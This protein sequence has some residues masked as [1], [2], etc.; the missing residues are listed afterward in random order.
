M[1]SIKHTQ[2]SSVSFVFAWP[3]SVGPRGRR[4][5]SRV[6]VI[7]R[8]GPRCLWVS[9]RLAHLVAPSGQRVHWGSR[10]QSGA[11]HGCSASTL[12]CTHA[13]NSRTPRPLATR[14]TNRQ[15]RR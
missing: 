3:L 14:R 12:S 4:V 7:I 15:V 13:R 11:P 10:V 6:R 2:R 1:I 8:A 5:Y 9:F